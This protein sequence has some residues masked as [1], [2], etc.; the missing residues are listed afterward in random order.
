[1]SYM[2]TK[3]VARLLGVKPSGLSS[4]VWAGRVHEPQ[5]GPGGAFLW[6]RADVERAAHSLHV[7]V[8]DVFRADK[9]AVDGN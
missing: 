6:T 9:G 8:P 3:Q 1:M 7:P 2:G 4:A 5:R